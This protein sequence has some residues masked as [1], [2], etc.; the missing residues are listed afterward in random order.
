[1]SA[2][3]EK[4]VKAAIPAIEADP[5]GATL[6]AYN[7][8]CASQPKEEADALFYGMLSES[9][10]TR[11]DCTPEN[12]HK[13]EQMFCTITGQSSCSFAHCINKTAPSRQPNTKEAA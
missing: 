8:L 5:M 1:M 6:F 9:L 10:K 13:A 7:L 3:A 11:D 4:I 12:I 2:I